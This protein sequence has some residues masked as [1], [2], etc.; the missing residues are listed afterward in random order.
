MSGAI[1]G[2]V[3][4]TAAV[5]VNSDDVNTP[6]REA[7]GA[8]VVLT[9]WI[10]ER[11]P[12]LTQWRLG[13]D[14]I[15][16]WSAAT[17]R[18]YDAISGA[19]GGVVGVPAETFILDASVT[20][21]D[22]V[23]LLGLDRSA[24]I[25]KK[26]PGSNHFVMFNKFLSGTMEN[27]GFRKLGF[28]CSKNELTGSG[29]S[30][31][32]QL[33]DGTN[34]SRKFRCVDCQFYDF[35]TTSHAL[36]LAG[37]VGVEIDDFF[38]RDGGGNLLWHAIYLRRCGEVIINNPVI[39]NVGAAGIK[40]TNDIVDGFIR[41]TNPVI[42]GASRGIN[43]SDANDVVILSPS[44][45]DCFEYG[46][47]CGFEAGTSVIGL[48]I[49]QAEVRRCTIGINSHGASQAMISGVI[50]D[51]TDSGLRIQQGVGVEIPTLQV[52]NNAGVLGASDELKQIVIEDEGTPNSVHFGAIDLRCADTGGISRTAF[53][54]E[55]PAAAILSID[56][57][58]LRGNQHTAGVVS[59][60]PIVWSPTQR[61]G[62]VNL[63]DNA[64][65]GVAQRGAGPFTGTSGGVIGIDRWSMRGAG[66]TFS[67]V[68]GQVT[69]RFAIRVQRTPGSA[70]TS[71]AYLMQIIDAETLAMFSGD[72]IAF[73]FSARHGANRSVA[74]V[75]V[76]IA[77]SSDAGASWTGAGWTSGNLVRNSPDT[78]TT[79]AWSNRHT[80]G[81]ISES[82][83]PERYAI[84]FLIPFS[85]TAGADDWVEIE[86]PQLQ[87]GLWCGEP[88]IISTAEELARARRWY[89]ALTVQ[90]E[91]G[92]RHVP[93]APMRAVPS[94]TASAGTVSAITTQGFELAHTSATA[95]TIT[96]SA[97]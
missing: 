12:M 68:T 79:E 43:I 58:T 10:N 85:G 57:L 46:I 44:I 31:A 66:K 36:I 67:R 62:R 90:T 15:N 9:D 33:N 29:Y 8:P 78:A 55:S 54:C 73:G 76:V 81:L 64:G 7:L 25:F 21:R 63:L 96:A 18:A 49:I 38:A 2:P 84:G 24:S 72:D 41:I 48:Q 20:P 97:E 71:D 13:A 69:G 56:R 45:S 89:Q 91:N 83:L 70:D 28:D 4:D 35:N 80:I 42:S 17:Q 40:V 77:R 74:S 37:F 30:G 92:S 93:L 47:R 11:V 53:A 59:A 16:D 19:G 86:L 5:T 32:I 3:I 34:G 87:R 75:R 27:I 95:S 88:E 61:P 51:C 6:S 65:F 50:E 26:S 60:S 39:R 52:V 94:V 82:V 14:A 23:T 1:V 22:N